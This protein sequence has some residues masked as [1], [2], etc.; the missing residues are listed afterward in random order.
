MFGSSD[1]GN[2]AL[3]GS[4]LLSVRAGP[5]KI[6]LFSQAQSRH[7]LLNANVEEKAIKPGKCQGYR[8]SA[9]KS[10]PPRRWLP[11]G[12]RSRNE[13]KDGEREKDSEPSTY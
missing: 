3:M 6:P 5:L 8:F 10:W 7:R 11:S 1:G 13:R 4:V 9:A 2:R 12:M